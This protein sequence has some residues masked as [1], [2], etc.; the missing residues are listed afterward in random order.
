MEH[1]RR[2]G[3]AA[4]F[5]TEAFESFNA[6]IRS[7]SIHSNQQSPSRDIAKA[8]AH[9]N[10]ICHILSGAHLPIRSDHPNLGNQIK[11]LI[12]RPHPDALNT[13]EAGVWWPPSTAPLTLVSKPNIITDYLGLDNSSM[14]KKGLLLV[15]NLFLY[16]DYSLLFY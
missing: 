16:F 13:D 14:S 1:I 15:S 9:G 8:F 12:E 11:K 4:L 2:F 7:K 5:A 6:V 3:P 10:Q